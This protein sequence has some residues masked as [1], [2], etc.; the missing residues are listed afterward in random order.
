M[1]SIISI[2]TTSGRLIICT[3][4][5]VIIF[6]SAKTTYAQIVTAD[7]QLLT[8]S[9]V[10]GVTASTNWLVSGT[11]PEV[12]GYNPLGTYSHNFGDPTGTAGALGFG[13]APALTGTLSL[14]FQ[15]GGGSLWNVSATN[16]SYAGQVGPTISMNQILEP[17]GGIDGTWNSA[18][19]AHWAV[20]YN[21][22]FYFAASVDGNAGSDDKDII[23]TRAAQTGYL[24][25]YSELKA[26]LVDLT[27]NPGGVSI[28]NTNF[29][30]YLLTQIQPQLPTNTTYLL[31]TW[32]DK[33]HPDWVDPMLSGMGVSTNSAFG[34]MTVAYTT[35]AIPEPS[36]L[37]LLVLGA[38]LTGWR[39]IQRNR[40]S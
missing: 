34:N 1:Q 13:M 30:S 6:A 35:G 33:T 29:T 10:Q 36:S 2:L 8:S 5:V 32:M 16:L 17:S 38:G 26:G 12:V 20:Q 39:R 31:V 18:E 9:A 24:L 19:A 22:D 23:F 37:L 40:K 21:L 27:F 11:D 25:P 15:S 14:Q 3:L 4:S 28:T 7:F